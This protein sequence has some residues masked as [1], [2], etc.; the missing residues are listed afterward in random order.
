MLKRRAICGPRSA[1]VS[2]KVAHDARLEMWAD[3][4]IFEKPTTKPWPWGLQTRLMSPV[5]GFLTGCGGSRDLQSPCKCTKRASIG[6]S[7][8]ALLGP[9]CM[10]GPRAFG[11]NTIWGS[12]TRYSMSGT[13]RFAGLNSHHAGMTEA[14]ALPYIA[15]VLAWRQEL[16]KAAELCD[17]FVPQTRELGELQAAV[18]AL[19]IGGLVAH[20]S[21]QLPKAIGLIEEL[22]DMTRTSP[23]RRSRH[24]P[25]ALRVLISSRDLAKTVEFMQGMDVTTT[26]DVN[27]VLTGQAIVAE[28]KSDLDEARDL[29]QDA[30]RRWADYGFV[31]EEGQAHLG[32]A[33]CLIA[34]GEKQAA[35][36]PLQK[37]RVIFSRLGAV[38]LI[39]ET[40][41]C[42]QAEAAS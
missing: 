25:T 16:G 30:A 20:M 26:R 37:A 27:C 2:P 15:Q 38:P 6:A 23:P 19:A 1:L 3:W 29:Y 13:R 17:R 10:D 39:E 5:V 9:R 33:R 22:L 41:S 34:L 35:T 11:F 36:E 32:L 8:A 18:P 4:R 28:A 31:L 24:L 14:V 7:A 42:L 12:G 40:D 21:G